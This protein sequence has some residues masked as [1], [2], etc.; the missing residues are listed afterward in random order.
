[1]LPSNSS[2]VH[3]EGSAW[4]KEFAEATEAVAESGRHAEGAERPSSVLEK[5][6]KNLRAKR[7]RG[8]SSGP[9]QREEK[10]AEGGRIGTDF[11]D[12][13]QTFLPDRFPSHSTPVVDKKH[14]SK[15]KASIIEQQSSDKPESEEDLHNKLSGFTFR[16][17]ERMAHAKQF[18]NSANVPAV[19]KDQ[20]RKMSTDAKQPTEH[21]RKRKEWQ[22]EDGMFS[23]WPAEGSGASKKLRQRVEAKVRELPSE[24]S[25]GSEDVEQKRQQLLQ[26]LSG[27]SSGE[28]KTVPDQPEPEHPKTRK[29]ASSTLAKLSRFSFISSEE[30]TAET[31]TAVPEQQKAS[32]VSKD[33]VTEKTSS[34]VESTHKISEQK[35]TDPQLLT[36]STPESGTKTS[37][38]PGFGE[39]LANP[40]KR[41]CFELG[42]GGSKGLLS[43]LSFFSASGIDDEALDVDWEEE[44]SK[45]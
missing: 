21:Q 2:S 6:S 22:S 10:N 33:R 38:K 15:R 1:M 30:N 25:R 13:D 36:N 42:S 9:L 14:P 19:D 29:V 31:S 8:M 23:E 24:E 17:K 45:R 32:A 26:K 41:K 44:S 20:R 3:G 5:S 12:L 18:E 35:N 27:L 7:L 37:T 39:P 40:K 4:E 28:P 16:P 11:E 34:A 43:G